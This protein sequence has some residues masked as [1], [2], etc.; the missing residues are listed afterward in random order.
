MQV[1]L[2]IK[3]TNIDGSEGVP[4]KIPYNIVEYDQSLLVPASQIES[5]QDLPMFKAIESKIDAVVNALVSDQLS[6]I[7]SLRKKKKGDVIDLTNVRS[8]TAHGITIRYTL[9]G[10]DVNW[11]VAEGGVHPNRCLNGDGSDAEVVTPLIQKFIK[12]HATTGAEIGIHDVKVSMNHEELAVV[13]ISNQLSSY[14]QAKFVRAFLNSGTA[15]QRNQSAALLNEARQQIDKI[16]NCLLWGAQFPEKVL[17]SNGSG[18]FVSVKD[19]LSPGHT[20]QLKDTGDVLNLSYRA[21]SDPGYIQLQKGITVLNGKLNATTRQNQWVSLFNPEMDTGTIQYLYSM[22]MSNSS[23]FQADGYLTQVNENNVNLIFDVDVYQ[24]LAALQDVL[25]MSSTEVAKLASMNTDGGKLPDEVQRAVKV[26]IKACEFLSHKLVSPEDKVEKDEIY[27]RISSA[28]IEMARNLSFPSLGNLF[29]TMYKSMNNTT[30]EFDKALDFVTSLIDRH[31]DGYRAE[32][33]HGSTLFPDNGESLLGNYGKFS[34]LDAYLSAASTR[35]YEATRPKIVSSLT[36]RYS[37]TID[38]LTSLAH[39]KETALGDIY[40]VD[41]RL[42]GSSTMLRDVRDI[43]A[44]D[45]FVSFWSF[46]N[47]LPF[48]TDNDLD[49]LYHADFAL[50]DSAEITL[51]SSLVIRNVGLHNISTGYYGV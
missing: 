37:F 43:L 38:Q 11:C 4:I 34:V 31:V 50:A 3:N 22:V 24:T 19:K 8:V 23:I 28:A 17:I 15:N 18:C 48:I 44:S 12:T 45:A 40:V 39:I 49:A 51:Q 36:G 35:F 42:V 2:Q 25:I 27:A 6:L 47:I 20:V 21:A 16:N 10:L 1:I 29:S 7:E 14:I 5:E 13:L 46:M 41:N 32:M 33:Q 9:P 30:V 26:G